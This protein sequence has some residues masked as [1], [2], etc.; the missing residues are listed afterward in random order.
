MPLSNSGRLRSVSAGGALGATDHVTPSEDMP[1]ARPTVRTRTKTEAS[2]APTPKES[3]LE[4]WTPPFLA[5]GTNANSRANSSTTIIQQRSAQVLSSDFSENAFVGL[6]HASPSTHSPAPVKTLRQ[7]KSGFLKL[8]NKDGQKSHSTSATTS[9]I[10]SP[11]ESTFNRLPTPNMPAGFPPSPHPSTMP[12]SLPR[13][14]NN[15]PRSGLS[16]TTPALPPSSQQVSSLDM[17]N[18]SSSGSD[19]VSRSRKTPPKIHSKGS[20]EPSRTQ[21]GTGQPTT[22]KKSF[23]SPTNPLPKLRPMSSAFS[24]G[25]P[26]EFLLSSSPRL[27]SL[28]IAQ[29][30][31]GG[32]SRSG[33]GNV[34]FMSPTT[35]SFSSIASLSATSSTFSTSS[36]SSSSLPTSSNQP[37]T[38]S[39]GSGFDSIPEG[40]DPGAIIA[41]LQEQLVS[42][43]KGYQIQMLEMENQIK[44][45]KREVEELKKVN[46]ECTRCSS[47]LDVE[48]PD[49]RGSGESGVLHRPRARTGT[50]SR[51]GS[52]WEA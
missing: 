38:Q 23:E 49:R 17:E 47:T 4:P 2:L 32:N 13:P 35:P 28:E 6:G 26:A 51:F 39:L 1:T 44:G 50:G 25:L 34:T 43:R 33:Y 16:N 48:E 45:L 30:H 10:S 3:H 36:G 46:G 20:T 5:Y 27:G 12:S 29:P 8:F 21:G 19:K 41:A 15:L 52:S 37:R 31:F 9:M 40:E 11:V 24:N 14:T 18:S 22:P 7:R 42:A